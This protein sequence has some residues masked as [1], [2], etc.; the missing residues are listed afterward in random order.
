LRINRFSGSVL[1][2]LVLALS[3]CGGAG[4]DGQ[5]SAQNQDPGQQQQSDDDGSAELD[6]I[7]DVVAEV[8][9]QEIPK[10]EFVERY[11]A[12]LQQVAGQPQGATGQVDEDA[13]K[14]QVVDSM[15][16]TELLVQEAGR[17]NLS[18]SD[19]QVDQTLQRLAAQNGLESVDAF[20][21]ALE[22][23]GMD[24]E[25]VESQVRVQIKVEQLVADEAGDVEPSDREIRALYEQMVARQRQAGGDGEGGGAEI[26]P[27]KQVRPQLE[28]Q[29]V[30]QRRSEVA[31][32]LVGTLRDRADVVVNL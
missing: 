23:E 27:L 16:S 7:P 10:D 25:E 22:K 15:I 19:D 5:S 18:V 26:P 12:R 13:V 11:Q 14:K 32:S 20:M 17:R 28:Q 21:V 4:G 3:A 6:R 31:Q 1:A 30:S 8:N 9:G 2:V 24:R 29:L